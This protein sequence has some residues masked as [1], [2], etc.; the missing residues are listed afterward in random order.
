MHE[1]SA[2]TLV[3][4]VLVCEKELV[5]VPVMLTPVTESAVLLPLVTV[6]CF[7]G[8]ATPGAVAV[9]ARLV[10]DSTTAFPVPLTATVCGEPGALS[11]T[12][13]SALSEP[14]D[15][16]AKVMA[17]V[18][19][20]PTATLAP[21]VLVWLNELASVPVKLIPVNESAAVPE[22]VRVIFGAVKDAPTHWAENDIEFADK[23][24]AG[25]G[26]SPVPERVTV[27]GEP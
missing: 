1:A 20:A 7:V 16:G 21:Q 4:Q 27:C 3:P 26:A 13:R 23:V 25:D 14:A 6:T 18:Q 8:A 2:A 12:P 17:M 9:K 15:L 10:E 11:A 5:F 19:L 22:F 24:T